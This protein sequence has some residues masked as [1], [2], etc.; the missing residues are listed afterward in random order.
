MSVHNALHNCDDE[1]NIRS[2][3]SSARSGRFFFLQH[4]FTANE[5]QLKWPVPKQLRT[6][7][8]YT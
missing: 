6:S 4:L 7:A 1:S 5:S 8:A 3:K 2:K